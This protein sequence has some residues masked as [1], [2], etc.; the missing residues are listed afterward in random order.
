MKAREFAQQ[1]RVL[2]C[3]FSQQ[4]RS[5]PKTA[6]CPTEHPCRLTAPQPPLKAC[7]HLRV[8]LPG[9]VQ[10]CMTKVIQCLSRREDIC[11]ACVFSI[12]AVTNYHT[13]CGLKQHMCII[14]Q[15]CNLKSNLGLA[16]PPQGVSRAI[17]LLPS[18]SL[19]CSLH[20]RPINGEMSC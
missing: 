16:E 8:S 11:T 9:A 15:F 19:Y 5:S 14:L 12:G 4:T 17:F 13:F 18:L 3:A 1:V 7:S 10:V 20:N 6:P 2:L